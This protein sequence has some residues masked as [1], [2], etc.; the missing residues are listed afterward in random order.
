MPFE[1]GSVFL[2]LG[3]LFDGDG[4]D[5]WD[6]A[7][8]SE[9]AK[10]RT[11]I[12]VKL[13]ADR[14]PLERELQVARGELSA[15]SATEADAQVGI[16]EGFL[17]RSL[18]AATALFQGWVRAADEQKITIKVALDITEAQA[19]IA[20]LKAE[21]ASLGET[22]LRLGTGGGG[23]IEGT[24]RTLPSVTA[25]TGTPGLVGVRG[26]SV[27]AG[28]IQNPLVMTME[29]GRFTPLGA[30]AAQVGY[31]GEGGGASL[32]GGNVGPSQPLPISPFGREQRQLP[33][34]T[35]GTR[36]LGDTTA[37]PFRPGPD[38][39]YRP[40]WVFGDASRIADINAFRDLNAMFDMN[41]YPGRST[42]GF[43]GRFWP[44]GGGGGFGGGGG[45]GGGGPADGGGGFGESRFGRF[46]F[47][48]GTPLGRRLGGFNP[49]RYG[50]HGPFGAVGGALGLGPEHLLTAGA[51]I[52]GSGVGALGGAGVL[53]L[54]SLGQMA[55]GGGSDLAVMKSTIADTKQL[56]QAQE[57]V[58]QA[59]DR[60]GKNSTQAANATAN[61]NV[62]MGA[63]GNTAGVKAEAGLA[64][65]AHALN[66]YWDLATSSARVTAVSILDQVVNLGHDYVPRVAAAAQRNL[67]IINDGIRP[68]FT[69]LQ[70]PQGIKIWN[71][72]ENK[73]A[74]DL[75]TAVHAFVGI[76]EAFLKTV[77]QA[78]TFTGKFIHTLD[79][80][81]WRWNNM[82]PTKLHDDLGKLVNIFRDWEDMIKHL[83]EDLFYLF[84]DGS[85]EGTDLIKQFD[86]LLERW[87]QW[88]KSAQGSTFLKQFFK[89]RK[90]ELEA[91]LSAL[92]QILKMYF[93]WYQ[94]LQPLVPAVTLFIRVFAQGL[95]DLAVP[96]KLLA[97]ALSFILKTFEALGK[98]SPVLRDALI[99]PLGLFLI[100]WKKVG[101]EGAKNIFNL[102]SHIDVLGKAIRGAGG[103]ASALFRGEGIGAAWQKLKDA[104]KGA[105]PDSPAVTM[106][107][108]IVKG[109]RRG[110]EIIYESIVTA[111]EK[112]AENLA[113]GEAAGG[114][115]AAEE[116]GAGV[117]AG[118]RVAAAEE[119][120][121]VAAG[122]R[123]AA[124]EM[125][126]GG[127]GG[128]AVAAGSGALAT[129]EGAGSLGLLA[130]IGGVAMSRII[131]AI[132]L[133]MMVQTGTHDNPHQ[134]PNTGDLS[135]FVSP[136]SQWVGA[137]R[138][139]TAQS[140][141]H[142][143]HNV[144]DMLSGLNPFGGHFMHIKQIDDT[145]KAFQH[146][147]DQLKGVTDPAKLSHDQL[148]KVYNEVVA[149]SRQKD[150][151]KSQREGLQALY[152]LLKPAK[153]HIDRWGQSFNT[154]WEAVHKFTRDSGRDITS[155]KDDFDSNMRL[156]ESTVGT[157]TTAGLHLVRENTHKMVQELTQAMLD[158]KVKVDVGM[159]EINE[160][161]ATAE[162]L[163]SQQWTTSWREMFSATVDLYKHHKIDTKTYL[164]DIHQ[165]YN[166]AN[167]AINKDVHDR[168]VAR[169]NDLKSQFRDGI[170]TKQQYDQQMHQAQLAAN[171]QQKRDL[172]GWLA[173]L[174]NTMSKSGGLTN[175][176][177][178]FI[179]DQVNNA[180]GLFGGAKLP[181][182]SAINW[183]KWYQ[184]G[185]PAG[186]DVHAGHR[187][188][189]LATGGTIP[190][191]HQFGLGDNMTLID[192]TGRPVARMAGD[193]SV[194]NRWQMPYVEAGLQM[195][196]FA[197]AHDLWTRVNRPHG[198]EAGGRLPGYAHG[199]VVTASQ[200]GGPGDPSSGRTGYRGDNLYQHPDSYAELNMGT[201][202]GNLPYMAPLDITYRGRT[203]RAYKRDIG[204]G[205]PG[206]SGRPRAIDLWFQ[207]AQALGFN[208]L[209]LVTVNGGNG[210]NV[211]V[212]AGGAPG[213]SNIPTPGVRGRGAMSEMLRRSFSVVTGAANQ[214][215][216]QI[217]AQSI[218][219]GS[220]RG[221]SG[222]PF[223]HGRY[224]FPLPSGTWTPGSVD[225]GWDIAAPAHTPEYALAG[226][227]V[228]GHGIQGFGP[229]APILRLDDGNMVYY[230]HAGP[231]NWK[232]VGSR[233][234]AGDV[235]SEIG[236]GIVGISTGPHLEIG[237]YPPGGAGAGAAMKKALGYAGGGWLGSAL[238]KIPG[239]ARG[240]NPY[241]LY[242]PIAP[243]RTRGTTSYA[244]RGRNSGG[245]GGKQHS[246]KRLSP[247]ARL[248]GQ[249][250]GTDQFS[251]DDAAF[252]VLETR[253]SNQNQLY[254]LYYPSGMPVQALDTLFG[255][256]AFEWNLL[257]NEYEALN[258]FLLQLQSDLYGHK[259]P[260]R[261]GHYVGGINPDIGHLTGMINKDEAEVNR[262]NDELYRDQVA[263]AVGR[264]NITA[265]ALNAAV[266]LATA[267]GPYYDQ[268][269]NN[270]DAA[271]AL[272]RRIAAIPPATNL[273]HLSGNA[274]GNAQQ[275]NIA[276]ARTR[277]QLSAQR[278]IIISRNVAIR[279]KIS[280]LN[281]TKAGLALQYR[282][283]G[284]NQAWGYQ[285][286]RLHIGHKIHK[287]KQTI[288]TLKQELANE[289]K[290]GADYVDAIKNIE[291]RLHGPSDID[292]TAVSVVDE[293]G[294][295]GFD[296][297]TLQQ[298]GA[299][300]PQPMVQ[301]VLA[302]MRKLGLQIPPGAG[303]PG[304]NVSAAAALQD[305]LSFQQDR[306][307]MFAQFGSNFVAAGQ[308]P[309][310]TSTQQAAGM[311]YFGAAA[312]PASGGN[313][314]GGG[315]LGPYVPNY[316][317]GGDTTFN[318]E[319]HF[320]SAP[321]PHTYS[322]G[323][324]HEM[325]ALV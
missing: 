320:G 72:L 216:Q 153:V 152:E 42:T 287:L 99:V 97:D 170:I 268:L 187:N 93:M 68:L 104:F 56:Y 130:R 54:G 23:I 116:E 215:I 274:Y 177:M 48:A 198:Y 171:S 95:A 210:V 163:G 293:L 231:G 259:T 230:G 218:G 16:D 265:R 89:D 322:A 298:Q 273:G 308:N 168:L 283:E 297:L 78:S 191:A 156:I 160:V 63:L 306:A 174:S 120:A 58:A 91:L 223:P 317:R 92:G 88:E 213:I 103:L 96:M 61:L 109:T 108:A 243:S 37:G 81:A 310:G 146:L 299:D 45:G 57:Q 8:D 166:E 226:G 117:A 64:K 49:F 52:L 214:F 1:A 203:A 316:A 224:I 258:P 307:N 30:Y 204:A 241:S 19:E 182:P 294:T 39:T 6:R 138:H 128:G 314:A 286:A 290:L 34:A 185:S 237:F 250:P 112:A 86:T 119:G 44:G 149:L 27:G 125:A 249:V 110:G 124:G 73:F 70:G 67:S 238:G 22:R 282:T 133:A 193:E 278:T 155:L 240:G 122:G 221:F 106:E 62:L 178:R 38:Q 161:L 291:G 321:D 60:Y 194:F 181:V 162:K 313:Y 324:R 219:T 245:H 289:K 10:A 227:T 17:G 285:L 300:V 318:I 284:F 167:D 311:Q 75:P 164:S 302:I 31:G 121:G 21:M 159:K 165:M 158:G 53:A 90:A 74:K 188:Q 253:Y 254:Q 281:H 252:Q 260:G 202:L 272:T 4:F 100:A 148:H 28:G 244:N 80:W 280:Q 50:I 172:D 264:H 262:L 139:W 150:L 32:G 279:D 225:Q 180:L 43:L 127:A 26:T 312:G 123:I 12:D 55:V 113:G 71:D 246:P 266:K 183:L 36:Y 2:R 275:R 292:P 83:T 315:Q 304:G 212:M 147:A 319:Q 40:N 270:T 85:N 98:Q 3:G 145:A 229:W 184:S 233:V 105:T 157:H 195:L 126:I 295:V 235:I 303:T 206:I 13:G 251:K 25:G 234:R 115:V 151:T 114:K 129:A 137:V 276:N 296:I 65:A 59:V 257:Y 236:A 205:G 217:A 208:G 66:V 141:T 189:G 77:D 9:R 143:S 5:K 325:E 211:N 134:F 228:I 140:G 239:F 261:H 200:Y 301:Q 220:L 267:I 46:L 190:G 209:D 41:T 323:L 175:S 248:I 118:G 309:F 7:V 87:G 169:Q 51:S 136:G 18:A 15:F 242:T 11:P 24:A 142:F 196:G 107:E 102:K 20:L 144:G 222:H 35:P 288:A 186:T 47:G 14:S 201:A 192:P 271:I 154:A 135:R 256:R 101:L 263:A 199:G 176:A 94:A 132:A 173:N 179:T 277:K 79:N 69:W 76:V 82:S 131:P 207:L 197:G 33:P 84:K 255:I 29:A 247:L 111:S 269:Q 232:P 305:F